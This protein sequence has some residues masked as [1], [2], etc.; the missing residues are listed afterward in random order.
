MVIKSVELSV[1]NKVFFYKN[2]VFLVYI[3][4]YITYELLHEEDIII[5]V[6]VVRF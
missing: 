1:V 2:L 6:I 3:Y 5:F 4:I